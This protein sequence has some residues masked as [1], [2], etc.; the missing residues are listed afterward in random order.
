MRKF[1]AGDRL[2]GGGEVGRQ[3]YCGVDGFAA[4]VELKA[5][6]FFECSYEAFDG[7][8]TAGFHE[9]RNC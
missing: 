5:A 6:V 8:P 4:D 3:W 2:D 1:V 9:M 7:L